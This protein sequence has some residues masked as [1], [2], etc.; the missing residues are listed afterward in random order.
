MIKPSPIYLRILGGL[1]LLTFAAAGC[2]TTAKTE[3]QQVFTVFGFMGE[4]RC[5]A[6]NND[7]WHVVK[8]RERILPGSTITTAPGSG[9]YL[10]IMAGEMYPVGNPPDIYSSNHLRVFENS[11]LKLEKVTVKKVAG[12]KIGDTRLRLS[13]GTVLGCTG[14]A[15]P[16]NQKVGASGNQQDQPYYEISG[17]NIVARLRQAQ[18]LFSASGRVIVSSGSATLESINSGETKEI[19]ARHSYDPLTGLVS[20]FDYQSHPMYFQIFMRPDIARLPEIKP[21]EVPRRPF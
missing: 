12:K 21:I 8:L 14:A 17:S 19:P 10:D 20:E 9:N 5:Q 1:T 15:P 13:K 2:K 11:V 7:Q 18:Y 16:S 4:A 3:R 6:A